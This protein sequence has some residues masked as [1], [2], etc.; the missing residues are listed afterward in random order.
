MDREALARQE[1]ELAEM[2]RQT[3]EAIAAA[4]KALEDAGGTGEERKG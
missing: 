4:R 2:R 3:D 1:A